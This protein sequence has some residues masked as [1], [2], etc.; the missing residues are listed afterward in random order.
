[1][2]DLYLWTLHFSK[3]DTWSCFFYCPI[4][5]RLQW[6]FLFF[7]IFMVCAGGIPWGS[8]LR[9]DVERAA[10]RDAP[11]ARH[12]AAGGYAAP[13]PLLLP[14]RGGREQRDEGA[15]AS[16]SRQEIQHLRRAAAG[17]L[18]EQSRPGHAF[19]SERFNSPVPPLSSLCHWKH[20]RP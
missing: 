7:F 9:G 4:Y 12:V 11:G 2:L 19:C 6:D 5:L 8:H 14:Q 20:T 10:L 13:R 18:A 1:M 3:G 17:T 15:R 16:H